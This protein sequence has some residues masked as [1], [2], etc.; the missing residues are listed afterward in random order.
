MH[1]TGTKFGICSL[2]ETQARGHLAV[3]G[4]SDPKQRPKQGTS[5]R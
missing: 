1:L 3:P 5:H 4:C 2:Q